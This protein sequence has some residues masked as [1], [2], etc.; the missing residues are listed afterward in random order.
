MTCYSTECD[1]GSLNKRK[2]K[3]NQKPVFPEFKVKV[4][5]IN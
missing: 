3:K 4:P 1:G 5:E 2:K